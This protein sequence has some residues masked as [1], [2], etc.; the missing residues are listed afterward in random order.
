MFTGVDKLKDDR[1]RDHLWLA[2][3]LWKA[4]HLLVVIL[5]PIS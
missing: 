1:Q 3:V 4:E 5:D 2:H